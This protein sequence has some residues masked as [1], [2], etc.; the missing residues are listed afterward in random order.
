MEK[1][2]I[3]FSPSQQTNN[4]CKVCSSEANHMREI[5]TLLYSDFAR[6][7]RFD[8]YL[9]PVLSGTD[10]QKLTK[11]TT[12]SNNFVNRRKPSL[13]ICGHSDGGYEG[14]GASAFWYANGGIGEKVGRAI[15]KRM[16]ELT[17]WPDMSAYP[18]PGLWE[19][20]ATDA[21]SALIEISFHDQ[22]NEAQWIHNNM[23]AIKD[24]FKYGIFDAL[25][26]P[27]EIQSKEEKLVEE[28]YKDGLIT[29]K[30]CWLKVLKGER[31][32]EL[33]WFKL[34]CERATSKI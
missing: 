16:C 3:V 5:F 1:M 4:P 6:D 19:M 11:G 9:I 33:Q 31:P 20:R 24:A 26:I 27:Y 30:D 28:M 13:H 34:I 29:D 8:P 22:L 21:S 14:H 25:Q 32:I 15:Y 7:E 2:P 12:L 17:P 10:N 23:I 18:R